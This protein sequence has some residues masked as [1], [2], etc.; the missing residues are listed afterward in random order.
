MIKR[1]VRM[2]VAGIL[3]GG[4]TMLSVNV[5]AETSQW[6]SANLAKHV[7]FRFNGSQK[8]ATE[9]QVPLM[10]NDRVYVPARF[11]LEEVGATVQWDAQSST[12]E[13]RSPEP[14]IREVVKEVE[15]IKEVE[16]IIY[17]E[18]EKEESKESKTEDTSKYKT[19]PID[20]TYSDMTVTASTLVRDKDEVRIYISIRNRGSVPLQLQ[21]NQSALTVGNKTYKTADVFPTLLDQR[22]Y[23][24]I[25]YDEVMEGYVIFKGVPEDAEYMHLELDVIKNDGRSGATK[26]SFDMKR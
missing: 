5:F 4:I 1:E 23:S 2:L 8:S 19:L 15:V 26:V 25:R 14:Q 24:D 6:V 10:Y 16:K 3:I 9:D 13:I 7:Q 11:V 18:V 17:V 20:R 12:V 21:Q 22:W